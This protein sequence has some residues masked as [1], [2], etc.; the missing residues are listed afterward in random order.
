MLQEMILH[1]PRSMRATLI[2]LGGYKGNKNKDNAEV[3]RGPA[4][5][6]PG[7][8]SGKRMREGNGG[9]RDRK[10]LGTCMTLPNN[11]KRNIQDNR[12]TNPK[13]YILS[14]KKKVSCRNEGKYRLLKYA[15]ERLQL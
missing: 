10:T 12:T 9:E 13:F 3:G 8:G 11:K 5:K 15:E 1:R 14:N 6:T 4:G 7:S 2:K